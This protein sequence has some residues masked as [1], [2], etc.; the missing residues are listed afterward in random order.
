MNS[1]NFLADA[2]PKVDVR[3]SYVVADN[4][5]TENRRRLAWKSTPSH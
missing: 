3:V 2:D 4:Q 5:R 1:G